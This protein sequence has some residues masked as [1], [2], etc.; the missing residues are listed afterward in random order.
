MQVS[1]ISRQCRV[2][3]MGG[4]LKGTERFGSR[5]H[6][7]SNKANRRAVLCFVTAK[8]GLSVSG[9]EAVGQLGAPIPVIAARLA[10][11]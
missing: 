2:K 8:S 9:P 1:S 11:A 4:S 5:T 7:K 3:K 6:R 10:I